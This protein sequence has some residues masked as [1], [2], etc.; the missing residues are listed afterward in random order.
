MTD[1]MT[2]AR[3]APAH[4]APWI[5]PDL[6]ELFAGLDFEAFLALGQRRVR[7]GPD[8]ARHTSWFERGGS[9]FYLKVHAGVG[10]REIAKCWLQ[11]KRA[12][13]D[14]RPEA[15]ALTRLAAIGLPAPRLAAFGWR[16]WNPARRRSFV[17][18][19]SLEGTRDLAEYLAREPRLAPRTR[20]ALA[21][22]LGRITGRL[23]AARLAHQ[24]LYLTHFRLR[25]DAHGDFELFLIDLH[26]CR[27]V[28]DPSGRW[29]LKDLA[30]LRFS[31]LALP[32]T[33]GD[34]ARFFAAYRSALGRAPS[35]RAERRLRSRIEARARA[36]RAR[37]ARRGG[38]D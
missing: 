18:T 32:A 22:A 5:R 33:R 7:S 12:V 34:C 36:V 3:A 4:D 6:A 37:I 19:E 17:V 15:E 8:G 1:R 14:A 30:A 29:R 13:V 31:T 21:R 10:W 28:R 9:A 35:R 26:R 24:D 2:R 27:S 16:G 23:H 20:A 38:A 11:G 25:G